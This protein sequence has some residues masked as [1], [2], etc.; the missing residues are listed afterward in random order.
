MINE[1]LSVPTEL[2]SRD[3]IALYMAKWFDEPFQADILSWLTHTTH[4]MTTQQ[5][6]RNVHADL[7]Y[8]ENNQQHFIDAKV[9]TRNFEYID[10]STNKTTYIDAIAIGQ[11]ALS[12]KV[13][14][15]SFVWRSNLYVVPHASLQTIT[16]ARV[17]VSNGQNGHK[18]IL[19]HYNV[20]TFA[21][22][23]DT[24]TYQISKDFMSVYDEAYSCYERA[25]AMVYDMS[26]PMNSQHSHT[27]RQRTLNTFAE[28]LKPIIAR[29]NKIS[30]APVFV[31][32]PPVNDYQ[33]YLSNI[34]SSIL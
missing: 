26:V 27:L 8:I 15:F 10:A 1:N 31:E 2:E 11:Y 24:K 18:Q 17:K 9:V 4:Y 21:S 32:L 19:Y 12:S 33:K 23:S 22:H 25:R 13:N 20:Q 16:P 6:D 5:Q 3:P 30:S 34:L 14:Y 7:Y 28:E 29:Y